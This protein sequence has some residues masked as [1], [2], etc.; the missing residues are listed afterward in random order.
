MYVLETEATPTFLGRLD[1]GKHESDVTARYMAPG[2]RLFLQ[3]D[4]WD[5]LEYLY[6]QFNTAP[7][8]SVVG[9]PP[10]LASCLVCV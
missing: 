4:V 1:R 8:R 10:P 5:M 3:T 9:L 6:E 2:A 7:F